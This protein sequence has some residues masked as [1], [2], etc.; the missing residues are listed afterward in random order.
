MFISISAK[1]LFAPRLS[2]KRKM[3]S[4]VIVLKPNTY[5]TQ[6]LARIVDILENHEIKVTSKG[7]LPT[8]EKDR[9]RIVGS[10]LATLVKYAELTE[11]S[12][13]ALS[14]EEVSAFQQKFGVDWTA[15]VSEGRVLNARAARKH[16]SFA[17]NLALDQMWQRADRL[18]LSAGLFCAR[19]DAACATDPVHKTTLNSSPVFVVNG[20]CGELRERYQSNS[21]SPMYL[22]IEWNIHQLSWSDV[23]THIIGDSDPQR[24]AP[25][26]IRGALHA[27]WESLGLTARP[28]RDQN[29]VHFSS[30]AFEAMTE[31]LVL[32]KG[33]ILFT[34]ALGAKLLAQN[35]PALAIQNW[36]SNPVVIG[37]HVLDHMRD[38]DTDQCLEAAAPLIGKFYHFIFMNVV[39]LYLSQFYIAF[40]GAKRV[41]L[42]SMLKSK[43]NLTSSKLIK[44]YQWVLFILTLIWIFFVQTFKSGTVRSRMLWCTSSQT[45]LPRPTQWSTSSARWRSTK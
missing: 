15:A 10:Y 35:I 16:F 9:S 40:S 44:V 38:K 1:K 37:K 31:R 12:D 6:A 32:C 41:Q 45:S 2:S 5:S 25:G 33:A 17:D 28:T 21:S 14:V 23:S 11:P 27:E 8:S 43:A 20:F 36:L 7:V 4:A 13:I 19:F 34:D 30:S 22:L 26:S 39:I 42:Q 24:A 18:R 3:E 29:C